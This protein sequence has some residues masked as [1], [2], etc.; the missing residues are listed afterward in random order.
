MKKLKRIREWMTIPDRLEPGE[1]NSIT[2]VPGVTVGQLTKIEGEDIRTG[3]TI[4]KPHQGNVFLKRPPAS[5]FAGNGHTKAAGSVQVEELGELESYIALTSTLSVGPVMQGLIRV[6]RRDLEALDFKSINVFVGETNDGEL[7]DILGEHITPGDVARC[8][9]SC[10]YDV[11]EGAVGAGTGCT[12]FGYKGGMGTSSRIIKREHT[13]AD[14]DYTLGVLLQ[15][16]YSGNLNIYGHQL[17]MKEMTLYD[18]EKKARG[19]VSIVVA[20]DA[21]FTDL[22]LRRIAKRAIVGIGTTGSFLG[23]SS[24]DYVLAFSNNEKNLRDFASKKVQQIDY[25]PNDRINPFF[26][27]AVSATREAVYNCLCMAEDMKGI[28]GA[29][30][31]GFNIE[32]F[33]DI[34]PLK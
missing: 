3:L 15:A 9:E 13:G 25:Y 8:A 6:H 26:E 17:P 28:G 24:G 12:C 30:F 31:K 2:D 19:S 10:G 20:T 22:Q 14:R 5:V 7:N 21:P 18:V 29:F 23:N 11:A 32:E 1:R 27:A 4:I 16:N 34:I 33:S